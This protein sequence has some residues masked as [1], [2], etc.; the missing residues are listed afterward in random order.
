MRATRHGDRNTGDGN[1][2]VAATTMTMTVRRHGTG[3]AIAAVLAVAVLAGCSGGGSGDLPGYTSSGNSS[4]TGSAAT[5]TSA[6]PSPSASV[7]YHPRDPMGMG[8]WAVL[9]VVHVR[10]PQ[11]QAVVDAY[12]RSDQVILQAFNTRVIDEAA[13]ASVLEGTALK[14]ARANVQWRIDNKLWTVDREV[15]NVLSVQ[16]SGTTATLRACNFDGTSE[17][18]K[19]THIVVQPPGST[20]AIVTMVQRGGVWRGA[21]GR[22]D[23]AKCDAVALM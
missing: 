17:V 4:G 15:L 19:T 8:A 5:T 9:G 6:A 21:S 12:L 2:L 22:D 1:S 18:D 20:G 13:L 14:G 7:T 3:L 11:E 10:S 23:P 16:I